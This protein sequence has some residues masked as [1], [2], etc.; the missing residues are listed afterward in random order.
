M[1]HSTAIVDSKAEI[2]SSV[3]IGPYSIINE[4]VVI[5]ANTVIGPHV[6]VEPY[7]TIGPDCNIFQ[8]VSLGCVPQAIK[9]EGEIT[10]VKIGRKTVLREFVTVNRGTAFGGGITEVGAEN[11]LMAYSHV[12]HDCKTG[13]GVI[14]ANAATLAGHITVGDYATIG[15]LVAV[16][17]FVRIG[18]YAYV[19]GKSAVVKDVPPYVIVAGD[20][21]KLFGLNKIGLQRQGFTEETLSILKQAYKL[22]FRSN[23]TIDEAV[24]KIHT[25]VE[26]I[27]EVLNFIDF[28]ESSKRGITR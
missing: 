19:G 1:I 7:V 10:H 20:R 16:H 8:F 2:D 14:F 25:E 21:A 13:R 22:I 3:E 28:I 17:Q 5:E 27:P 23:L 4:N 26:Q 9:F 11:F 18:D 12:A 6:V 24:D 15:G